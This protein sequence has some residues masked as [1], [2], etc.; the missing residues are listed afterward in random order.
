[1]TR[2]LSAGARPGWR[3]VGRQRPGLRKL[4]QA[5]RTKSTQATGADRLVQACAAE[6]DVHAVAIIDGGAPARAG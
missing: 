5:R 2:A 6:M 4:L 3:A 1:V